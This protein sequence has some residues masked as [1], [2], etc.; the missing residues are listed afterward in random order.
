[1]L[2]ANALCPGILIHLFHS[3]IQLL[4]ASDSSSSVQCTLLLSKPYLILYTMLKLSLP[5][6]RWLSRT[7][8]PSR[9]HLGAQLT[10]ERK[11]FGSSYCPGFQQPTAEASLDQALHMSPNDFTDDKKYLGLE[12]LFK[13]IIAGCNFPPLRPPP[14]LLPPPPLPYTFLIHLSCA[15]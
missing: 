3:D 8:H 2:L 13:L 9:F 12:I 5:Q 10:P 7:I 4:L 6:V 11:Y 14:L 15:L 1:M